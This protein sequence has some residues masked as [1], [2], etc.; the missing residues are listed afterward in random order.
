MARYTQWCLRV[1]GYAGIAQLVEHR[2]SIPGVEGSSP[3][4]RSMN[5]MKI[6]HFGNPP[7]AYCTKCNPNP[8]TIFDLFETLRCEG[9]SAAKEEWNRIYQAIAKDWSTDFAE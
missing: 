1:S 6:S 9:C 7:I 3:F 5:S 4:T 2:T 8:K